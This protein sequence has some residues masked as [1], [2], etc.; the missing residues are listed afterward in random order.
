MDS[1]DLIELPAEACMLSFA[2]DHVIGER[3]P[4]PEILRYGLEPVIATRQVGG[5]MLTVDRPALGD[6]G[7]G[8]AEHGLAPMDGI[9]RR[10]AVPRPREAARLQ[11]LD[12]L[13]IV[14]APSAALV[15]ASA[16]QAAAY[17]PGKRLRHDTE[18]LE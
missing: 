7:D 1:R 4:G 2:P 5:Q 11:S 14:S 8:G 13:D 10:R 18:A 12:V 9:G 15:D 16:H 3:S 6:L 17:I